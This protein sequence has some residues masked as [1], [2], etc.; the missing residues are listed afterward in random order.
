MCAH[1][2]HVYGVIH[3]TY[4]RE[5]VKQTDKMMLAHKHA[6]YL[7]IYMCVCARPPEKCHADVLPNTMLKNIIVGARASPR[8]AFGLRANKLLCAA[9]VDGP[10]PSPQSS[11]RVAAASTLN[12]EDV[13]HHAHTHNGIKYNLREKNAERTSPDRPIY[14]G[15]TS[16]M[17]R[18]GRR[19]NRVV[20]NPKSSAGDELKRALLGLVQGTQ[21][22]LL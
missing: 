17:T 13:R 22:E 3:M 19:N 5:L 4:G 1:R 7:Y 14:Y 6:R 21:S 16:S 18:I 20:E 15:E 11:G 2:A 10:L 8:G 9:T 12:Q